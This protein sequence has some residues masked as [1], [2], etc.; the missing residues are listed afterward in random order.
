[1]LEDLKRFNALGNKKGILWFAVMAFQP[2]GVSKSALTAGPAYQSDISINV[3]AAITFF[4]TIGLIRC[5]ARN[6]VPSEES[7]NF[8]N[9]R[10]TDFWINLCKYV[11]RYCLTAQII[12][13][14]AYHFDSEKERFYIS[15]F[16]FPLSYSLFRNILIQL[17]ALKEDENGNLIILPAFEPI[18]SQES[19]KVRKAKSLE[20]LKKQLE[21]EEQQGE[22][23][24]LFA[25][26]Y[27]T[28]RLLSLD[29]S[30][31]RIPKR[32]STIDVEAGFDIA[33]Y[34]TPLSA[35]YDRFIEVK[36]FSGRPHFY[37]SRNEME[38]AKALGDSYYI[39]LVDYSKLSLP[40][41]EPEIIQNPYSA[42]FEEMA[43]I[44]NPESFLVEKI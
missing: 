26:N 19:A 29:S 16:G 33:S 28:K 40:D 2:Q 17:N 43:W 41:Y 24:E 9:P 7:L 39:Y 13:P 8:G 3:D 27:E 36:T 14:I 37:W 25:L 34:L 18:F 30:S 12:N 1:M 5:G 21:L 44:A 31:H 32:I 23:G 22:E 20:D 4:E 42:I 15:P 11:I 35:R 38:K 6:V 10:E